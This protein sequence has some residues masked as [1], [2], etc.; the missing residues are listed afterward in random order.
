LGQHRSTQRKLPKAP[1][2][3]AILTA[4][5]IALARQYGRYG[6]R[7][8]TALLRGA[9]GFLGMTQATLESVY[10]HHHSDHLREAANTTGYRRGQSFVVSLAENTP[11][12]STLQKGAD[13]AGKVGGPGRTRTCNQIVMSADDMSS[14]VENTDEFGSFDRDF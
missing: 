13:T 12:D 9:S 4:D 14:D 6:Y 8:I 3:E 10:G 7:R 5:V 2:D 11:S 1:D